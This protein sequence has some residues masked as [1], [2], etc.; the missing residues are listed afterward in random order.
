MAIPVEYDIWDSWFGNRVSS[1]SKIG[2]DF[3][4]SKGVDY[5]LFPSSRVLDSKL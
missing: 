5:T 4:V 1:H 2:Y 3:G